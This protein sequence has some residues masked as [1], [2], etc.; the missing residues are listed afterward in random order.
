MKRQY[1]GLAGLGN[2]GSGISSF[3][4]GDQPTIIQ[5][6]ADKPCP[7]ALVPQQFGGGLKFGNPFNFGF[8]V[9]GTDGAKGPWG[10]GF[11]TSFGKE[12]GV[13]I[14]GDAGHKAVAL[15]CQGVPT[16]AP[17]TAPVVRGAGGVP[18]SD[19]S[20]SKALAENPDLLRRAIQQNPDLLK[21]DASRSVA[22]SALENDPELVRQALLQ[23]PGLING[24]S[25]SSSTGNIRARDVPKV[26]G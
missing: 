2:V 6:A 8:D 25:G 5:P 3:P 22:V 18:L 1:P 26:Q 4:K 7:V 12:Y 21:G 14:F 13:G 11:D 16:P 20:I 19:D 10:T 9:A 24:G 15:P 17:K 23:N